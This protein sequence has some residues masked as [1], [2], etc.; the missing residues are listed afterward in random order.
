MGM[1]LR[2]LD[3]ITPANLR[4]GA[5]AYLG[6]TDGNWP[7][8]PGLRR[9]FPGA[10]LLSMAVFAIDNA[11]GCDCEK[12][13]LTIAQ[14]PGWV[15]RQH[16]RGVQRPVVY[17]SAS[18]MGAAL[19]ALQAAGI[20]RAS[21]RLLSAHYTYQPHICGP[22]T[23]AYPGCPPCDGTQWTDKAQ[24]L[25]GSLIDESLLDASFF[26]TPEDIMISGYITG[27]KVDIVF[28]DPI[29]PAP[30]VSQ[31]RFGNSMGAVIAVDVRDG[32]PSTDL[33]LTYASTE[34]VPVPS[35]CRMVVV[36]V[37]TPA[38]DGTPVGYAAW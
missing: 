28:P 11:E 24:G 16:A 18:N 19:A 23:C 6:Y 20:T 25:N 33:T 3:S 13:D 8:F 12:G 10:H 5:D 34:I 38:S 21:V 14:V 4:P 22:A 26:I 2:M 35:G 36:H 30:P 17:A 32:K 37:K 9:M 29:P 7:T 1:T 15:Q 31:I 27:S